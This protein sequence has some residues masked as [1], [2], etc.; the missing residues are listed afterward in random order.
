MGV[1]DKVFLKVFY[2]YALFQWFTTKGNLFCERLHFKKIHVLFVAAVNFPW[3]INS[4]NMT[5]TALRACCTFCRVRKR[6]QL[7]TSVWN[8]EKAMLIKIPVVAMFRNL[9][10]SSFDA[11][12]RVK[13]AFISKLELQTIVKSQPCMHGKRPII[14]GAV[15]SN[16]KEKY[17]SHVT[18]TYQKV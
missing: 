17:L 5:C 7:Q 1:L 9:L 12:I 6:F 4:L 10:I 13:G 11:T 16:F 3:E 8:Y 2:Y 15:K 14:D 18:F